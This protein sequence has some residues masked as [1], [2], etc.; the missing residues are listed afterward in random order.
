LLR[1]TRRKSEAK[2]MNTRAEKIL[3]SSPAIN[4]S[5]QTIDVRDLERKSLTEEK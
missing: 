5:T 2:A 4:T 1:E 3:A